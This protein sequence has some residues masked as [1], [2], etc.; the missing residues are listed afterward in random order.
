MVEVTRNMVNEWAAEAR[1]ELPNVV[2]SDFDEAE[3]LW[4]VAQKVANYVQSAN[5]LAEADRRVDAV[6]QDIE[7]GAR[8]SAG[9]IPNR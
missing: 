8:M 2:G 6:R 5:A 4:Y 3:V 7:R 1:T 9:R